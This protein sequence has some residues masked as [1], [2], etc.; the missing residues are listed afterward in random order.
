MEK[1]K[2]L[3]SWPWPVE[4]NYWAPA[5][6]FTRTPVYQAPRSPFSSGQAPFCSGPFTSHFL[7]W[8]APFLGLQMA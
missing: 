2:N 7:S 8:N 6:L 3:K 1:K 4:L 5:D